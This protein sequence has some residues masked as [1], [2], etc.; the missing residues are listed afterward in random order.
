MKVVSG[1]KRLRIFLADLTHTGTRVATESFP[2]NVGY[3]ASYLKMKF[4]EQVDIRLFKYPDKLH[5]ALKGAE[6]DLLGCSTYVWNDNLGEWAFKTA[7]KFNPDVITVRGG[8][9]FPLGGN[10]QNGY[11]KNHPYTDIVCLNEGETAISA[12]VERLLGLGDILQWRKEPIGGG[13]LSRGGW[14]WRHGCW[15]AIGSD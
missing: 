13:Y 4:G 9:N 11:L 3:L 8:W 6:C 10:Q 5:E 15:R 1:K 7:R 12:V 14:R 2:L